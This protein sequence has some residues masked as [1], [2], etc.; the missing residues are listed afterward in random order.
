LERGRPRFP[1]GFTVSRGT[2]VFLELLWISPTGLSPSLALY[3][4]SFGYPPQSQIGILQPPNIKSDF[5][6]CPFRSPLTQ[7]ITTRPPGENFQFN[8]L[9]IFKQISM[10]IEN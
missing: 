1:Q 4:E 2:Q 6:L 3:S 9:T 7:G 10:K 8:N 5:G